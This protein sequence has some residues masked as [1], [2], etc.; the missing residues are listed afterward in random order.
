VL[1]AAPPTTLYARSGALHVAYQVVGDGPR[2]L[3]YIPSAF[4]HV[5]MYWEQP[6]VEYFLRRLASFSRLMIFDKRGTG[7]SDRTGGTP[8]L[9]ERIDDVRAVMDAVGSQRA[10]LFGMSE[11]GAIGAL[12]AA[13]YPAKVSHLVV[14]GSGAVGYV[15]PQEAQLL[16]DDIE[17]HWG[18]GEIIAKGAPSVADDEE[19]RAWTGRLQHRSVSPGAMA[20]LI[21][22]NTTFDLR[23]ELASIS[24]PTLVLHRTG[25]LLYAVDQGRYLAAHI[26]GARLVELVGTDHL[27]YY[28]E[29]DRILDLIE[30]FVTDRPPVHRA[31]SGS[32]D[33]GRDP[34]ALTGREREVLRLITLGRTNR[35]IAAELYI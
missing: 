1:V 19:I 32:G 17:R 6:S 31:S 13:R 23:D 12:F 27:P 29:P 21:R 34:S 11:G 9:E 26:P 5:E 4:G 3:V 25:D 16:I 10:A 24:A 35:Q 20:D 14:M 18:N 22:M 7:M 28:E 30:E 33:R 8:T 2:D 15:T